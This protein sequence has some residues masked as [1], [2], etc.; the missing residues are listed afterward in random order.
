MKTITLPR[1]TVLAAA[2]AR[3]IT[4][5]EEVDRLLSASF[6]RKVCSHLKSENEAK[7]Q[8]VFSFTSRCVHTPPKE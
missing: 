2:N 3:G 7:D 8:M 1:Q 6:G 5:C 4:A